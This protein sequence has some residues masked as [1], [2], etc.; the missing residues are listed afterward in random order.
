MQNENSEKVEKHQPLIERE[1]TVPSSTIKPAQETQKLTYNQL[2]KRVFQFFRE[3]QYEHF[4]R[5]KE[6]YN[7]AVSEDYKNIDILCNMNDL[8]YNYMS[9]KKLTPEEK[10]N[11]R[12][13]HEALQHITKSMRQYDSNDVD[14]AF[15][16]LL[17]G[18]TL[19]LLRNFFHD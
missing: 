17:A 2:N 13:L 8:V 1:N 15:I 12:N 19:K 18:Y 10:I 7:K 16:A 4:E 5:F 11:F 3:K 9:S 6:G 14:P